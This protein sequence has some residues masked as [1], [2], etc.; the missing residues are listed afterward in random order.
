ME[1]Q[2]RGKTETRSGK[3]LQE[4]RC[5]RRNKYH[6]P[7]PARPPWGGGQTSGHG[8]CSQDEALGRHSKQLILETQML[9]GHLGHHMATNTGNG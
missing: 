1:K 9:P 4:E 8:S 5:F 6:P 2:S 7:R 3:R